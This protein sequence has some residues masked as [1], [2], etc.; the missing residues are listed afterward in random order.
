MNT[1]WVTGARQDMWMAQIHE[2]VHFL[3]KIITKYKI[4]PQKLMIDLATL[5]RERD[6]EPAPS[7]RGPGLRAE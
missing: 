7:A 2:S 4:F 1:D 6:E 3:L 5:V